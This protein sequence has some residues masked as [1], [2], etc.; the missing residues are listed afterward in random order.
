MS[1]RETPMTRAYWETRGG[2]LIEEFCV[3]PGSPTS[4]VR[5]LDGLILLDGPREIAER[6]ARVPIEGQRVEV[7]QS[8]S[9]RLGMNVLGQ[10]FFSRE[11]AKRL[12]P[13]AISTVA[14]CLA[15]DSVLGPIARE[16]GVKVWVYKPPPPE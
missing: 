7:I 4:G 2:T 9:S 16:F 3:V 13:E 12:S 8:K 5:R 15:D 6:G 14:V 10:A 11:L 1:K